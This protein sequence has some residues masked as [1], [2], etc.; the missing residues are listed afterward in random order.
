MGCVQELIDE[1]DQTRIK[2]CRFF[3]P[4]Q[5]KALRGLFMVIMVR[6]NGM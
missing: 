1:M 5:K 4:C 2:T 3:A 6:S